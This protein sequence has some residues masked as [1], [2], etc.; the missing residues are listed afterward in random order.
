M[1]RLVA[2]AL[3]Q[4][5]YDVVGCDPAAEATLRLDDGE[6]RVVRD[7]GAAL[8]KEA[9]VVDFSHADCTATLVEAAQSQAARLVIGTTGQSEAQL[10]QLREA[11]TQVPVLVARNFS[12]GI[13][14]LA[15]VL[16]QLGVLARNGFDVECIEAHHRFK[17]DAPSGT[18]LLL[19]EA[20]L[21]DDPPSDLVHGRHGSEAPRH[22]GEVGVHSLRAGQIP[23][24]HTLVLAG[25]HEV[26]ELRHRALDRAAFVSGVV[27]AVRFIRHASPGLHSMLD[28]MR[29]A[30]A[31][32]S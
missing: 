6:L 26:L 18:T 4:A 20:L 31:R 15:Q 21:G 17:R 12:I 10:R 5:G 23:G 9:V 2:T 8:G 24:E 13:N 32:S 22:A 1:G 27:P 28:V 11:S 29:D 7:L 14:R 25:E 16:P 30:E 3:R 19:L